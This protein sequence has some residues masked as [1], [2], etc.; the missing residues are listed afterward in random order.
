MFSALLQIEMFV[1]EVPLCTHGYYS[2]VFALRGSITLS[3]KYV[4]ALN[5]MKRPNRAKKKSQAE[6]Q[7]KRKNCYDRHYCCGLLLND[8][9]RFCPHTIYEYTTILDVT[10]FHS[11]NV[12]L[13]K[14]SLN[15]SAFRQ[16]Q[17]RPID[18]MWIRRWKNRQNYGLFSEFSVV[19]LNF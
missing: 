8:K 3:W 16:N 13:A 11:R 19:K 9:I 7:R 5:F 12:S 17:V 2:S 4:F 6:K 18:S 10:L 14:V 15:F 1:A